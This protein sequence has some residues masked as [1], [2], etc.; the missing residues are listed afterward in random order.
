MRQTTQITIEHIVVASNQ[1]YEKVIDA[2]EARLGSVENWGTI[3]QH[4]IAANASQEQVA[5][6]INEHKPKWKMN[7]TSK[8][9]D[10]LSHHVTFCLYEGA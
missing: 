8:T 2:L 7:Q 6:T 10:K 5:Q 4:L 1:P 9:S 3:G